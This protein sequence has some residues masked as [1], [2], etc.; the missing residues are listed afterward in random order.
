MKQ[1]NNFYELAYL[2]PMPIWDTF[3]SSLSLVL[4]LLPWL[5]LCG[6]ILFIYCCNIQVS[7]SPPVVKYNRSSVIKRVHSLE[8]VA[9][10]SNNTLR[11]RLNAEIHS[12]S[13]L[14]QTHASGNWMFS[15]LDRIKTIPTT[16]NGEKLLA[17]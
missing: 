14:F 16:P 5:R 7:L 3:E 9:P 17:I 15:C 1:T 4:C 13:K 2:P 11:L 6:T 8:K 10:F 12:N